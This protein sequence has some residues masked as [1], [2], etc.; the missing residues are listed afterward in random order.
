MSRTIL[1]VILLLGLI[2]AGCT[3]FSSLSGDVTAEKSETQGVIVEGV[4]VLTVNH[5]AGKIDVRPG[6]DG[7]ITANLTKKSTLP[8][9]AEAQAQL[10][11]IVMTFTQQGTDVT[12][13]IE[14]P[15][16]VVRMVNLPMAD[17]EILVPPGTELKLNLG[18]GDITVEQPTGD[19]E[20]NSGAGAATAILP[21]DASFRLKVTGGAASVK[22]DFEGVPGGGVA[23]SIDTTVGDNP[24]QTLIFNLG[25]GEVRLEKAQ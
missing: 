12:L 6:D 10:D 17:L 23:T 21:A 9:E 13:D 18:A 25:A 20:V 5:F 19:L 2:L 24:A 8:D 22:S 3:T 16:S 14:G 1:V 4:P 15:E 7:K 11:K